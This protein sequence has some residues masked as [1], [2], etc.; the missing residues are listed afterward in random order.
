MIRATLVNEKIKGWD[1][2]NAEPSSAEIRADIKRL[3]NLLVSHQVLKD[4]S[5]P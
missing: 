5:S 4:V 1:A 2:K 3:Q